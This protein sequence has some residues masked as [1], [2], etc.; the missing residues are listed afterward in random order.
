MHYHSPHQKNLVRNRAAVEVGMQGEAEAAVA[1]LAA[2]EVAVAA[3]SQSWDTL[4]VAA[5]WCQV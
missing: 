1:V 5:L 3:V 2:V 4:V